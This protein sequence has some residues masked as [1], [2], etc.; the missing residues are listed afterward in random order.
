[1]GENKKKI[2]NE[3]GN[4]QKQRHPVPSQSSQ[5]QG[6]SEEKIAKLENQLKQA[7]AD[8]Q[9]L[10]RDMEKRLQFE[11]ELVRADVLKSVIGIADDID[12]AL[13]QGSEKDME[14]WRQGVTFILKKMQ[15]AIKQSGARL[16][17]CKVGDTFDPRL[18]EAVGILHEGKDGTIAN[19]VQ[20]G[21]V[22]GDVLV[23]PARVIVN[24]TNMS[25]T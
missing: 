20:N 11:G 8:Y 24:K 7:L 12:I 13:S 18:H 14:S 16:I 5:V 10:K 22:L 2:D 3:D 17:E 21:Y 1:M 4:A 23:R 6:E 15:D 25:N 19:V 9:N